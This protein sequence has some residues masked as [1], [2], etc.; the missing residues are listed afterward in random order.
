MEPECEHGKRLGLYCSACCREAEDAAQL[1]ADNL[2]HGDDCTTER[3]VPV[4]TG[5]IS[6]PA[7]DS[8]AMWEVDGVRLLD[9]MRG[10]PMLGAGGMSALAAE[11]LRKIAEVCAGEN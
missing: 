3:R 5:Y 11:V 8:G 6:A 4:D 7:H 10:C 2:A 9:T 1:A